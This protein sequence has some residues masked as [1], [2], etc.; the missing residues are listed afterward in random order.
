MNKLFCVLTL[1]GATATLSAHPKNYSHRV[2]SVLNLMTLQEKVGQMIQYSN[3]KLLTGPALDASNR[4]EEVKRGEVGSIFNITSADRARQYQELAM[5]SR[6]RIPLLF[7]LDVVHGVRTIFP[8]PLAE[9]ASFNLELMRQTARVA[10]EETSA[11]GIHWTFAPMVDISRDARWGRSMEGAGEDTWYGSQVARAR[12]EGFQ[13]D[14]YDSQKTVMA[15]AKH[16]AAYGAALSGR[17]YAEADVSE[18]TLQQVYLPPFQAAV[19]AGVGTFMNAFNEINGIPATAHSGLVRDVLKGDWGFE[20]FVVS[21]WGSVGEIAKHRMAEDAKDAGRLAALA[22]CDM[23]MHSMTYA[24]YLVD[25]VNEGKVDIALIDDA[26]R[27][28]LTKK[29]ELGL[30]DDPYCYNNRAWELADKKIIGRHRQVARMAGAASVVLLKNEGVLPLAA[31][32]RKVA[33]V[34]PLNR[35]GKDL[36]GNWSAFGKADEVVTVYEGLKNA[37]PNATV[38]YVEGYDLDSNEL[39]PLPDLAGYDLIVVSVGERAAESGEG[40][41]KVNINVNADQQQLVRQLKERSKKP[42]VALVMGGRPLIFKDMEP[43]ADAILFT[44]W[45]GSEAGNAIADVLTGQYNP[46][47]KLPMTFPR[48]VGQCPIYYNHKSTGRPWSPNLSWATRYI[49]E[50]VLPAYAFDYGLSYTTFDISAPVLT[51]KQYTFDE[52]VMLTAMVTNTGKYR[53]KE[54]VQLYLQDVASSLTR[55]VIELCGMQQVELEPGECREV[56]FRLTTRDLGFYDATGSFVTEPG[57]FKLF[58]GNS[59][60]NLKESEFELIK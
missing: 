38:T 58:V 27:R 51:K 37:L 19:E 1:C 49:D 2:D 18:H 21:D 54:T 6:L 46:S 55:P 60:D 10:A 22:G 52:S 4:T 13:G 39:K 42:V 57:R 44:W 41:S 34:G 45:L 17:D 35:S 29:F 3:N 25:L 31:T 43:Y 26:V 56:K 47:G 23:D 28:I 16:F 14:G 9:A 15:C 48:N 30:F 20:G 53:G 24:K 8:I 40:K 5:Q 12:V 36:L 7:G 11:Y 33:L 50:S 32:A 59:S